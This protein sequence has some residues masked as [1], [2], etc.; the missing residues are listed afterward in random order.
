MSY[1]I[2]YPSIR[3]IR[4]R[5]GLRVRLPALTALCFLLFL[6]L[7]QSVWPEGR[8]FLKSALDT[9][10]AHLQK[11]ASVMAALAEWFFLNPA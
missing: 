11:N 10:A 8:D 2:H 7:V 5:E 1:R 3:K 6:V 9:M 4:G